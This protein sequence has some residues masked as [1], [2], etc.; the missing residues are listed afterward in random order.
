MM[1]SGPFSRADERG[2]VVSSNTST[3]IAGNTRPG[4]NTD[5]YIA[6]AVPGN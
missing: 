3:S 4:V 2:M 1:M 6:G 5:R